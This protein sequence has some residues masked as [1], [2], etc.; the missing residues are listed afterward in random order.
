M[1]IERESARNIAIMATN[2]VLKRLQA[3]Q[4]DTLA[5][6]GG[7]GGVRSIPPCARQR[8]SLCRKVRTMM[9]TVLQSCLHQDHSCD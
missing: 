6:V 9:Q 8:P 5:V 2:A 7:L 3:A 1:L 4:Q